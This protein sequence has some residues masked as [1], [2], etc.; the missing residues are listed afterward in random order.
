MEEPVSAADVANAPRPG[1]EHGRLDSLAMRD[2][3]ERQF[4]RGVLWI[5]RIPIEVV[6]QP[7]RGAL[8]LGDR[9]DVVSRFLAWFTSDDRKVAFF[10]TAFFET[11]FGF[12]VGLRARFNEVLNQGERINLRF[13]FGGRWRRVFDVEIDKGVRHNERL[14]AAFLM[15]LE[16]RDKERFFGYGNG[17]D[18]VPPP[19]MPV[20]PTMSDLAIGSRYQLD[21]IRLFAHGKML[22]PSDMSLSLN[23]AFL[24]D[25]TE[26]TDPDPT[27]PADEQPI[28]TY[29]NT[30]D[31]PGFGIRNSFYAEL[32]AAWD[33]RRQADPFDA[34][35]MRGTGGLIGFFGGRHFG[36]GDSIDFNRFGVDLQRFFRIAAGPRSFELRAWG[37]AVT[38]ARDEVPFLELPKLGGERLL[39]GY[40]RDRFRDRI[41]AVGQASYLFALSRY[42]ATSVFVDVG[43][44]YS[45]FDDLTF[46]D[47]R[48]GFGA[49]LELYSERTM[50][51][52]VEVAGS[53]DGDVFAYVAVDPAFDAHPRT[54]RR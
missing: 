31:I 21:A 23:G 52:R 7:V 25:N 30:A 1:Q 50:V 6:A 5:P 43:R 13:A 45:G 41:A 54:E 18:D 44:V 32:Y 46:K 3:A 4:A 42:L 28:D 26:P 40:D 20:D 36:G 17:D 2:S 34:P 51:I 16:S 27:K 12:N 14:Q 19:P 11:G 37:E 47:M 24:R 35:A 10:P 53:K 22:M 29:Y 38:G 15:R 33:T 49:A 48:F 9:Y 39:R 8:Y